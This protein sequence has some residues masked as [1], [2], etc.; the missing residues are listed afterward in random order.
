MLN[1]TVRGAGLRI[2]PPEAAGVDLK[3]ASGGRFE[4]GGVALATTVVEHRADCSVVF[5][6]KEAV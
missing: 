6:V 2:L 3:T 4:G 5:T 1:V